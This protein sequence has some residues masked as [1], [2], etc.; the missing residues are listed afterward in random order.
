MFSQ[1]PV[2]FATLTARFQSA[3]NRD[4]NELQFILMELEDN[5]KAIEDSQ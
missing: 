5:L 2:S 1:G 4:A 3:M